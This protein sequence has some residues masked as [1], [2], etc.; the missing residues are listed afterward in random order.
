MLRSSRR[1]WMQG[2]AGVALMGM[3][4]RAV[5]AAPSILPAKAE[6]LPLSAVRLRPSVYATAVET[7]RRY[8][9]RLSPDRQIASYVCLLLNH[10]I[11]NRFEKYMSGKTINSGK[12]G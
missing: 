8:L 5:G 2:A 3:A 11:F 10:S 1:E 9:Y 7:N 4:T 12:S 6:P